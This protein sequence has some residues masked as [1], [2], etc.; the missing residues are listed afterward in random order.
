MAVLVARLF[1]FCCGDGV[2]GADGACGVSGQSNHSLVISINI[3]GQLVTVTIDP[4]YFFNPLT[5]QV[6]P[7]TPDLVKWFL[8]NSSALD[9]LYLQL[10]SF[11]FDRTGCF[12]S[13]TSGHQGG[14][15]NDWWPW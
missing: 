6:T 12:I 13:P 8:E 14:H 1:A 10:F 2:L 5:G 7:L 3:N 15:N 4:G 11:T 9:T